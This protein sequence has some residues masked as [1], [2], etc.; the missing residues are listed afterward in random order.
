MDV[1]DTWI[2]LHPHKNGS[3]IWT[4]SNTAGKKSSQDGNNWQVWNDERTKLCDFLQGLSSVHQHPHVTQKRNCNLFTQAFT[5]LPKMFHMTERGM[6][7]H[8][9]S[10]SL[11]LSTSC[12]VIVCGHMCKDE[13]TAWWGMFTNHK[14]Q[15]YVQIVYKTQS[16]NSI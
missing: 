12:L 1:Q 13:S 15:I 14:L 9:A 11:W 8:E 16:E 5:A 6:F 7:T 10:V 3:V 2:C 4:H